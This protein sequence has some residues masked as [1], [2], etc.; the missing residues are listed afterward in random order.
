M[1]ESSCM[2]ILQISVKI[3]IV[4]DAITPC[5]NRRVVMHLIMVNWQKNFSFRGKNFLP[6]LRVLQSRQVYTGLYNICLYN[7]FTQHYTDSS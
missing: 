4:P 1:K 6:L 7:T 3:R 2:L 5:K